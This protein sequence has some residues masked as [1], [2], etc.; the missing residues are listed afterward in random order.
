MDQVLMQAQ[1]KALAL[2]AALLQRGGIVRTD[3]FAGL[4]A[5][6]SMTTAQTDAAQGEVL[7]FWSAMI[8]KATDTA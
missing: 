5:L 4:M 7:A 2:I 8:A 1:G 6:L 3:E